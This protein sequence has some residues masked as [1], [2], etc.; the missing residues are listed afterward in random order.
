[1][2]AATIKSRGGH[3]VPISRTHN[4][5]VVREKETRLGVQDP[6]SV[7]GVLH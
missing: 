6:G 2:D 5:Q 1:V 3:G 7:A 4:K